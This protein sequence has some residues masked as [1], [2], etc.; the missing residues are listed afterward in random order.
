[1]KHLDKASPPPSPAAATPR[2]GPVRHS[3]KSTASLMT[4]ALLGLGLH[5]DP[6][7][8]PLVHKIFRKKSNA[9][10]RHNAAI[11]LALLMR[12]DAIPVLL[13]TLNEAGV[14]YT[15]AAMV[16]ALGLLPEPTEALGAWVD[17][18]LPRRCDAEPRARAG[19][20]RAG[21]TRRQTHDSAERVDHAELQTITSARSPWT[22][23]HCFSDAFRKSRF[24]CA[25]GGRGDFLRA[26]GFALVLVGAVAEALGVH[27]RNHLAGRASHARAGLAAA[28]RGGRPWR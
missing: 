11:S 9:V 7:A 13:E 27:L 28:C 26:D 23:C 6:V 12:R 10:A 4:Y 14:Q 1:M 15:K 21:F 22:S 8:I 3:A 17:R 20:H 19:D 18:R 16:M 24:I 5:G 25:M 2:N